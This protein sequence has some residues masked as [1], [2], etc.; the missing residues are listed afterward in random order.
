MSHSEIV[1]LDRSFARAW[2]HWARRSR[3]GEALRL[4]GLAIHWMNVT[5]PLCNL[6]FLDS[7]VTDESDLAARAGAA[8]AFARDR[9]RGWLLF[10]CPELLPPDLRG[11]FQ[12]VLAQQGLVARGSVTGMAADRLLPPRRPLPELE[13]RSVGSAET[14]RAF[15][16]INAL[17]YKIPPDW[18]MEALGVAALWSEETFGVVGY[19][20]GEPVT[21]AKTIVMDDVLYMALV[22]TRPEQQKKG[23]A[24]AAMRHSLGLAFAATGLERTVLHASKAGLP[25]YQEMGYHPVA[26]FQGFASS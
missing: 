14:L 8:L 11:S 13:F 16:E 7:P 6:T 24:E 3:A 4:P 2:E 18:G 9:G 25:L 22:A 5:W 1:E 26:M 19:H 12:D 15:S 21:T 17:A 23:F 10:L 20:Q